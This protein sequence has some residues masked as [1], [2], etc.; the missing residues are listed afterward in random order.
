MGR[1]GKGCTFRFC[2]SSY[3]VGI[4][5]HRRGGAVSPPAKVIATMLVPDHPQRKSPRLLNYDYSRDGLYFIAIC[6]QNRHCLFGTVN[7]SNMSCNAAGEMV[8]VWW[9]KLSFKFSNIESADFVVMP[10]HFH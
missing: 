4:T 2:K 8:A 1:I 9:H 10:N 5:L 7:G 3:N 6:V